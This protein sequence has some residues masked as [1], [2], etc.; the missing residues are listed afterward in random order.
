M[1]PR[2]RSHRFRSSQWCGGGDG[3]LV[4]RISRGGGGLPAAKVEGEEETA[5]F[6]GPAL[7]A[8]GYILRSSFLRLLGDGSLKLPLRYFSSGETGRSLCLHLAF[9]AN[10]ALADDTF[11]ALI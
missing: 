8:P 7:D 10:L 9:F 6:Q 11:N 4:P 5:L 3:Y 2:R 1:R